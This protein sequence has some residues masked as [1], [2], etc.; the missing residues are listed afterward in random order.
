MEKRIAKFAITKENGVVKEIK[1][2]GTEFITQVNKVRDES[3]FVPVQRFHVR[4][5]A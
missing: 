3:F 4:K 5:K 1:Q 2:A